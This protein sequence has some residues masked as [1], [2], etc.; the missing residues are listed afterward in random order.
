[1]NNILLIT[2]KGCEACSIASNNIDLALMQT[3]KQIGKKVV[4][5]EDCKNLIKKYNIKDFPTTVYTVD[6]MLKHKA[7]GSYP[8]AVYLRWIDLHFK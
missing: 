5:R 7:T 4:D 2:T 8:V 3:S 1:M 6:G